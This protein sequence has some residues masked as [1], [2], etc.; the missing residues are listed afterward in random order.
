MPPVGNGSC[1]YGGL[2][3]PNIT[4]DPSLNYTSTGK[5]AVAYTAFVNQSYCG[6]VSNV[7][8]NLI[9][10]QLSPNNGTTW[11]APIYLGNTNCSLARDFDSAFDPALTSLANGTLVLSYIQS[12]NAACSYCGYYGYPPW[13][14]PTYLHYD[15]LVVQE[16]Y[17][18]GASWT[19]PVVLNSSF[20][21]GSGSYAPLY[22]RPPMRDWITASGKDVYVVWENLSDAA[23]FNSSTTIGGY[24]RSQVHMLVSTDGGLTFANQTNFRV[25]PGKYYS[26]YVTMYAVNP[27]VLAAPNGQV[28]VAYSTAWNYSYSSQYCASYAPYTCL[29]Y[30]WTNDL[31]VANSSTNGSTWSY[32]YAVKNSSTTA[33][34]PGYRPNGVF[35]DPSPVLAY[36]AKYH[37]LVIGYAGTV[38]G[39]FC[40]YTAYNGGPPS[41][42]TYGT[43]TQDIFVANSSDGGVS[44]SSPRFIENLVNPQ[45][46]ALNSAYMPSIAIDTNGTVDVIATFLNDT[47]CTVVNYTSY[48]YSYCGGVREVY[49]TSTTNGSSFVGPLYIYPSYSVNPEQYD[50]E[51]SSMVVEGS[52]VLLAWTLPSCPTAYGCYFPYS[53]AT[54]SATVVVSEFFQGPGVTITFNETNLTKGIPWSAELEGNARSGPA[55]TNLTVSGV[56]TGQVFEWAVSTI[57]VSYG[58]QYAP[59]FAPASPGSFA[60]ASAIKATFAELVLLN[61]STIPIIPTNTYY[62]ASNYLFSPIPGSYWYPKGAGVTVSVTY[63]PPSCVSYC[64]YWNLSFLSL[65]GTGAGSVNTNASSALV[66]LKG[67]VNETANFVFLSLCQGYG[68]TPTCTNVSGYAITFKEKGL[69][70]GV[71]WSVTLNHR[72]TLS[73][74]TS[75]LTFSVSASY[76][77]YVVWTVPTST[78]GFYW[79]PSE[80]YPS[81]VA[82]PSESIVLVTFAL[83]NASLAS[84]QLN[85]SESGLPNQ[86]VWSVVAGPFSQ[87]I[88]PKGSSVNVPGGQDVAVSGATVYTTNGI[89]YQASAV[90]YRP[91]IQNVTGWSNSTARSQNLTFDGPGSL[92]I[93]FAPIFRL[94][95]TSS[96]G[97]TVTPSSQWVAPGTPVTLNATPATGYLFLTWSGTGA[98][99]SNATSASITVTPVGPVNEFATFRPVP[100]PVYHLDVVSSGLPTGT[101]FTLTIGNQS[102]SG[103]GTFVIGSLLGG[104]YG[105]S[106]APVYLNAVA[107]TRF[108]PST[109][110]GPSFNGGTATIRGNGTLYVNFTTQYLLTIASSANGVTSPLAGLYWQDSGSALTLT[111]TPAYHYRFAGWNGSGTG[112][113]VVGPGVRSHPGYANV[114]ISGPVVES[115]QFVYR[116]FPPPA[117]YWLKVSES[118]LP[119]GTDWNV[120]AGTLGASGT[121][122]LTVN[123]LNGSV[124][125]GV[126]AVYVAAGVRYMP[127]QGAAVAVSVTSNGSALVNFTEQFLVSVGSGSGGNITAAT[128]WVDSGGQFS[129]TA[130]PSPGE[131]FLGW[132]G[133][134]VGAYTGNRSSISI[135]VTGPVSER[136][137]FS[138]VYSAGTT[139]SALAGA[140]MAFGSLGVLLVA[141]VLTGLLLGRR[142]RG[143]RPPTTAELSGDG[144]EPAETLYGAEAPVWDEGAPAETGD[145]PGER[146][147]EESL[148]AEE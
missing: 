49:L 104:D 14:Y 20:N 93:K 139:G 110:A 65:S 80:N 1:V 6:N 135:T 8:T 28:Y 18:N 74:K 72:T 12:G 68:V 134:G 145:A 86:T 146:I 16:S 105:V 37:Q 5:L 91:F 45:G 118:G 106:S 100:L 144:P 34:Y 19:T 107:Q 32:H 141:G 87:A 56:P 13:L 103:S 27:Y 30:I 43:D 85:V 111:A 120:T 140:P 115:A 61:F 137:S 17:T 62:Q 58:V 129:A 133:S 67:P 102:Y 44:W 99:S 70:T 75:S 119:A 136:A 35:V 81:P 147:F 116:V 36:G 113:V 3:C 142:R 123:G 89:A 26:S 73:S 76:Q 57:S 39:V 15:R 138:P 121:G 46:G 41:C 38:L 11:S 109:I 53:A 7:T 55:G 31:L 23:T 114:T 29:Y 148:P 130:T 101:N 64:Y 92:V 108:V 79:V 50:G 125:L 66:K 112:S 94:T 82:V 4:N 96:R 69:P 2:V 40:Q 10:F 48:N 33:G 77:N 60:A 126:A 21:R 90:A 117:L 124:T 51:Y 52:H 127:S 25:I 63:S 122:D 24:Y 84:F 22:F 132:N 131:R 95:V 78:K 47:L 98:G 97:G 88:A 59:T 128:S 143:E 54:G 9:G 42:Y 83:E 71:P